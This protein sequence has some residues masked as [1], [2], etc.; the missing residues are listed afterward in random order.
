MPTDVSLTSS[1][2]QSTMR[3]IPYTPTVATPRPALAPSS[4]RGQ[5]PTR[6]SSVTPE[7]SHHAGLCSSVMPALHCRAKHKELSQS[8]VDSSGYSSSEGTYRKPLPVTSKTSRIIS[9]SGT[10]S[11][12]Y[13]NKIRSAL[14]SLMGEHLI[15]IIMHL[16]LCCE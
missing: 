7:Q 9:S 4:S 10:P 6:C 11:P 16:L 14:Y 5:T 3:T 1:P 8:G 15:F 2:T 12:G 13:R